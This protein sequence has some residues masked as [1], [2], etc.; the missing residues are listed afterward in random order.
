MYT[1]SNIPCQCRLKTWKLFLN[2][3]KNVIQ[4]SVLTLKRAR[5]HVGPCYVVYESNVDFHLVSNENENEN[6]PN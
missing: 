5:T 3:I 4:E 1:T 2:L 6:G